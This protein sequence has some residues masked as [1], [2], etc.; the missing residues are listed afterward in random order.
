MDEI[1][2]DD[3]QQYYEGGIP[4]IRVTSILVNGSRRINGVGLS[5]GRLVLPHDENHLEI[6]FS[7][8]D[9]N[10]EFLHRF[11]Y[12]LEGRHEHGKGTVTGNRIPGTAP[13]GLMNRPLLQIIRVL[14]R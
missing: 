11:D 12:S 9:F 2:L 7:D 13:A 8:F 14:K 3:L 10:D 4:P 1:H 6:A 5:D